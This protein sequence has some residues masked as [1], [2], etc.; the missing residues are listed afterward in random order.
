MKTRV[1]VIALLAVIV[2]GAIIGAVA[3]LQNSDTERPLTA[4]EHL[5]LGERYLLELNFEQAL[6]HFTALI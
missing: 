6:V 5:N 1:I 2:V 4:A 3:L